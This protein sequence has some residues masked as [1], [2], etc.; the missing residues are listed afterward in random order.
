MRFSVAKEIYGVPWQIESGTLQKYFPLA[1]GAIHGS[2]FVPEPEPQ[3]NKPF[4]VS[5]LTLQAIQEL[6]TEASDPEKKKVV[7]VLPVRGLMLKHDMVCGPVGTR[8]LAA[9]LL[10]A[11]RKDSVIGH[12]M[13]F[14]TG[15]G[16]STS[17]P[18][19]SDAIQQC[20]KPV[21]AWV[22][23][24]MASA[25]QFVG[26]YCREIIASRETDI[27]GSI[28]TMIAFDGRRSVS[29]EDS[30]KVIHLRIYADQANEKNMEYETAL[31]NLDFSL[32]KERVLNPHNDEFVAAVKSLRPGV[33][34]E[35]LHGRTFKA[36]EVL[37][38]LVD[39]IGSFED[40][41]RR[42]VALSG[43]KA[44][45]TG[46]SG[47][48]KNE[49]FTNQNI[50][51]NYPRICQLLNIEELVVTEDGSFLNQE[52]LQQIEESLESAATLDANYQGAINERDLARAEADRLTETVNTLTV[53][54]DAAT[55][56]VEDLRNER[57]TAVSS[58]ESLVESLDGIHASIAQA[59]TDQEKV[60]ALGAI[61][62]KIPG[63]VIPG[64]LKP[65][66]KGNTS[67][68]VDW[69]KIN[70]L[71]H[72]RSVDVNM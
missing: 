15:G 36:S 55:G 38:A 17:V 30:Q 12:V 13:V 47:S 54:R 2:E 3:I 18:E 34:D 42:V 60:T 7:H 53:E 48:A 19:L 14:E 62:Q 32:I 23:G 22:D 33:K 35:H 25:G 64:I 9:R 43:Y 51:N 66:N 37:G 59:A 49:S 63:G 71:P 39:S 58:R 61:L 20:K 70:A 8:T 65:D 68:G 41:L 67:N 29:E 21:V 52:Q 27:V 57:D 72:N 45:S 69:D 56:Q 40:A 6:D 24:M 16:T 31:N 46:A 11:D 44:K 4:C 28:G 10:A 1:V 50:M 26:S 5:A